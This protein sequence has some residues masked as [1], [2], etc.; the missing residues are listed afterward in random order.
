M[1]GEVDAENAKSMMRIC[2]LNDLFQTSRDFSQRHLILA[3]EANADCS[4]SGSGA[5][6]P[7]ACHPSASKPEPSCA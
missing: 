1:S 3:A 6:C 5:S 4:S 7:S 2:G